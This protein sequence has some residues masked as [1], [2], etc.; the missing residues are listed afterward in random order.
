[1]AFGTDNISI[2]TVIG[3]GSSIS[4]DIR[5]NGRL[6]VDGDVDGNLETTS[7]IHV[8]EASRIHGN[9]IASSAVI[10]GVVIGDITAPKS[11]TLL[12]SSAVIGDVT[13]KR[14]QVEEDV[15]LHG[16]CISIKDEDAFNHS[17]QNYNDQRV[18]RN[19]V[20]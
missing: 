16:H 3:A 14:L 11:I 6:R 19:K 12:S 9:I 15:V 1:M 2:N 18:I 4:G 8:G 10:E 13:T 17:V 7:N 20:V 5:V